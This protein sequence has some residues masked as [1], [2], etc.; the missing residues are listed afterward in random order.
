MAVRAHKGMATGLFFTPIGEALES[1]GVDSTS[2]MTTAGVDLET[3]GDPWKFYPVSTR[4]R[5]FQMAVEETGDACF[6]LRVAEFMRPSML[7]HLGF[8]LLASG[9]LM[10]M[11]KRFERFY[12]LLST[13]GIHKVEKT[14]DGYRINCLVLD[15]NV[16]FEAM[17]AWMAILTKFCRDIY[18]ADF[19]PT[20][21]E[22]LRPSPLGCEG[23]L[24]EWF[25]CPIEFS[26]SRL[27]MYID[28]NTMHAKLAGAVR[29]LAWAQDNVLAAFMVEHRRADIL[30][31]IQTLMLDLLPE[32]D[33][34]KERIAK[35]CNMSA[36]TLQNKLA[37]HGTTFSELLDSLRKELALGY[38]KQKH[39]NLTEI[40]YMLGFSDPSCFSRAFK[41]WTGI[42]PSQ[43]HNQF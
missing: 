4:T 17:D 34:N 24:E 42:S 32:G 13:D 15:T 19:N 41:R 30:T 35:Q 5:V 33:C 37:A 29:E 8:S 43:F 39:L 14:T 18:S 20:K 38:V 10:S 11:F 7:S 2:F 22:F 6:G 26:S 3:L 28:H 27:A 31:Q 1:Y 16:A 23:Q 12:D 36:R 25:G 40:T 21:L 9:T